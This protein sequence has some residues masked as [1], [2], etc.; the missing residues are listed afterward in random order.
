M[1][2]EEYINRSALE[3]NP[4]NW[5][6]WLFLGRDLEGRDLRQESDV[7]LHS[8]LYLWNWGPHYYINV[9][10]TSVRCVFMFYILHCVCVEF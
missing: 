4:K 5:W 6:F 1:E 3:K 2:G 8:L 9:D 7:S 10:K